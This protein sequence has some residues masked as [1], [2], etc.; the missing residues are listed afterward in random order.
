MGA[1]FRSH[2]LNSSVITTVLN[3]TGS[4]PCWSSGGGI[5][6]SNGSKRMIVRRADVLRFLDLDPSGRT[7]IGG[8]HAIRLPDSG[9]GNQVPFTLGASLVVIYRTSSDPL[10]AIVLYDGGFTM[11][12]GSDSF[13]LTV[14]GFYQSSLLDPKARLIMIVG[15]GQSNFSERVLFNGHVIASNPFT[16]ALGDSWDSP[17]FHDRAAHTLVAPR[18]CRLGD[19]HDRSRGLRIVRLSNGGRTDFQH[20]RPGHGPRRPA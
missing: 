15:D 9:G 10:R 6:S 19:R 17:T 18:R 7:I 16:G 12:H 5:G 8:T 2:D 3:P 11:D 4:S 14:A 1:Q 13:S 20:D